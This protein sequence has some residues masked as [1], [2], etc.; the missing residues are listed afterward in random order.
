LNTFFGILATQHTNINL[1]KMSAKQDKKEEE[2]KKTLV[3][4][5]D[6]DEFE[7]FP[8]EGRYT[9]CYF[10]TVKSNKGF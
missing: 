5:E 6:D 4:L 7:D 2:V 3:S 1:N 8:V 9:E 10:L